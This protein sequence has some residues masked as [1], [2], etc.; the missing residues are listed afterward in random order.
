M[1][2]ETICYVD[3]SIHDSV[4][5]VVSAFVFVKESL[6][7]Q[8]CTLLE[9][10]GFNPE[11]EEFKSSTRMDSDKRMR[12]VRDRIMSI[13]GRS[14]KIA[15]FF[16]PFSR[17]KLGRQSLQALQSVVVRN[18]FNPSRLSVH[19][20]EEM[21]KSTSEAKRLHKLFHSL[22]GCEI[23][24]EE[25]SLKCRGIQVADAVAHSFGQIVKAAITGDEKS[26]HF[27]GLN[28]GYHEGT[29]APLSWALLMNL[30]YAMLTRP[31]VYNG[32]EYDSASD[33]VVIDTEH[34]DAVDFGQHPVLLGWGVQVAPE[35]D[36]ELREAVE[37]RLGKLWLGCI[38]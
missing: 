28:T 34:D 12:S 1:R 29:E 2:S 33:P 21:F 20:D 6:D 25:D 27:G 35:S 15:V 31:V 18:S 7:N 23:H 9:E 17:R 32:E 22:S 10:A 30:R 8:V 5:V 14:T 19:F 38:H 4:G 13:A 11:C 26:V 36:Y 37:N 24:A 3:E 16:G